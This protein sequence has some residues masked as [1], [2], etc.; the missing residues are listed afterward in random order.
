MQPK[1]WGVLYSLG[2]DTF[3]AALTAAPRAGESVMTVAE[4]VDALLDVDKVYNSHP[5]K[6][7][8]RGLALLIYSTAHIVASTPS[9]SKGRHSPV[10]NKEAS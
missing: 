7:S 5:L 3:D 1:L 10:S 8:K 4:A 2:L 6:P 9:S